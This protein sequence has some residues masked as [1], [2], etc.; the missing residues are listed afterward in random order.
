MAVNTI[1][2]VAVQATLIDHDPRWRK[3]VIPVVA[4]PC[5]WASVW[6][7]FFSWRAKDG[8]VVL[9]VLDMD[10]PALEVR[11]NLAEHGGFLLELLVNGKGTLAVLEQVDVPGTEPQ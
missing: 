7:G 1:E 8:Q 5:G 9:A 2:R 4:G 6:D 11:L 10:L 3:P